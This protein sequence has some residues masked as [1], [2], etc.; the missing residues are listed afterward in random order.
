M[1]VNFEE[2]LKFESKFSLLLLKFDK[3]FR[4]IQS[5]FKKS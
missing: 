5:F 3:T 4:K 1:L 2:L